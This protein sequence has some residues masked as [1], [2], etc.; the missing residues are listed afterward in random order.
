[1]LRATRLPKRLRSRESVARAM[2]MVLVAGLGYSSR[3]A[4][5]GSMR[6]ARRAGR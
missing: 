5:I 6:V 1:M 3:S 2:A 4:A